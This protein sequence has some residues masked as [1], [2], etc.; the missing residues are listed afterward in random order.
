MKPRHE[1]PLLQHPP[2]RFRLKKRLGLLPV[3]TALRHR[4]R[5]READAFLLSFPKTGR[6]WVRVMLGKLFAEHY[7]HAELAEGLLGA[8]A[9][10]GL[11][12]PHVPGVPRIVVR[13]DGDPHLCTPAEISPH[14][15]EFAGC[16]VM[17]LV[18]DPRDAMV[19]NYFQVTRRQH[20]FEGDMSA[21]LRWPRGSLDAMLRYYNVWAAGRATPA[22]FM[23]LRYEDLHRDTASELRRMADFLGLGNVADEAIARAVEHGSF[24]AMKRR[25]ATRGDFGSALAPGQA[26]VPESFKTRKGKV[27]GYAEYL[28]PEDIAWLDE[29]VESGLDPWY[30]YGKGIGGRG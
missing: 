30:G 1:L 27:G 17:L 12:T 18:R 24:G 19:S 22:A 25:E 26:L 23:L 16:R 2:L 10:G 3:S 28:S 4:K 5:L 13:H 14:R 6:T 20:L 7:G 29:R 9:S 15:R 21:F 8:R 11:A